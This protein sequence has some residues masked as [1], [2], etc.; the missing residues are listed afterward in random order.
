MWR[1]KSVSCWHQ[2][3]SSLP[4]VS[5][6]DPRQSFI[7]NKQRV[8]MPRNEDKQKADV[9]TGVWQG[10]KDSVNPQYQRRVLLNSEIAPRWLIGL[11]LQFGTC[12]GGKLFAPCLCHKDLFVLVCLKSLCH[13]FALVRSTSKIR[14][15]PVYT[16]KKPGKTS[17]CSSSLAAPRVSQKVLKFPGGLI[18]RELCAC[19]SHQQ[20]GNTISPVLCVGVPTFPCHWKLA[21]GF[22]KVC[23]YYIKVVTDGELNSSP[24]VAWKWLL[25]PAWSQAA[26]CFLQELT[27]RIMFLVARGPKSYCRKSGKHSFTCFPSVPIGRCLSE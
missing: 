18:A 13:V 22:W 2:W 14:P 12:G 10:E 1:R 21:A 24:L 27:P 20:G 25:L 6:K 17:P 19:S 23:T 9:I 7:P 26:F 15:Y 4:H 8:K 16:Y 5:S 3:P 11:S